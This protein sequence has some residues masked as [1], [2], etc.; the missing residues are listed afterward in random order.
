MCSSSSWG[1]PWQP[2][3]TTWTD[4]LIIIIRGTSNTS[5]D[6]ITDKSA[7]CGEQVDRTVTIGDQSRLHSESLKHLHLSANQQSDNI[8]ISQSTFSQHPH[9]L[10]TCL[11]M[12]EFMLLYHDLTYAIVIGPTCVMW[13]AKINNVPGFVSAA[14]CS[15]NMASRDP[16]SQG[17]WCKSHDT[18]HLRRFFGPTAVLGRSICILCCC[19]VDDDTNLLHIFRDITK[20][21]LWLL[22]SI[23]IEK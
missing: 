7:R 17:T 16:C 14:S 19:H 9:Q 5:S 1:L 21:I 15:G 23:N 12:N 20:Q 3:T 11:R 10:V 18:M 8:H 4:L 6:H 2:A 13:C 22:A